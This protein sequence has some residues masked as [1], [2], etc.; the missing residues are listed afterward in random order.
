MR[1]SVRRLGGMPVYVV[2]HVALN[3][4]ADTSFFRTM[5]SSKFERGAVCSG[6]DRAG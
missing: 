1:I 4:C 5:P 2:P 6:T 3:I